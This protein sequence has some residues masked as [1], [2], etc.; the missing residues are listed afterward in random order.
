[1]WSLDFAQFLKYT[2]LS[3]LPEGMAETATLYQV[4]PRISQFLPGT[5]VSI[6]HF[7]DHIFSDLYQELRALS[8]NLLKL[9]TEQLVS[10]TAFRLEDSAVK[11]RVP[12]LPRIVAFGAV[13]DPY[14]AL[15]ELIPP[16]REAR[17][18]AGRFEEVLAESADKDSEEGPRWTVQELLDLYTYVKEGDEKLCRVCGALLLPREESCGSSYSEVDDC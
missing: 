5:R 18:A 13:S 7:D 4:G 12:E 2:P 6:L 15:D 11:C 10:S 1:M 14:T 3:Q 17:G 9:R 8:S 16:T